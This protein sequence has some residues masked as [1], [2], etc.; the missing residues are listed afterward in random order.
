VPRF[1]GPLPDNDTEVTRAA[2]RLP[3]LDIE[4]V[5]RRAPDGDAEQLS[6]TL[7]ATPSFDAVAHHLDAANPFAFWAQAVQL[8]WLPWLETTRALMLPWAGM[9]SLPKPGSSSSRS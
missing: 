7:Q 3:G 1:K 4:I 6:I 5:H 2:A 9:A 8:A